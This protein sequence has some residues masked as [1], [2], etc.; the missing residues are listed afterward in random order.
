MLITDLSMVDTDRMDTQPVNIDFVVN[1]DMHEI[2]TCRQLKFRRLYRLSL[3]MI[4][5]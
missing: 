3:P 2:L 1:V 5:I 4:D